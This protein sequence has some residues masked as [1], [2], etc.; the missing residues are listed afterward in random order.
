MQFLSNP[1]A[2]A[3]VT[4]PGGGGGGGSATGG[5]ATID[6][7][8]FPGSNEA[9][10]TVTGQGSI[11]STSP[12]ALAISADD[13]TAD[14]SASDHSYFAM[15]VGLSYGSVVH[16]TGFTI[17]ARSQYKLQGTFKVRWIWN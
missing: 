7:G 3:G 6:F 13:T 5:V 17:Y 14:H 12:I 16:A 1:T 8:A 10:I 15:V 9:S 2:G 11:L 4:F